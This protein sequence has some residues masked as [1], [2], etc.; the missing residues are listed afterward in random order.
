[1]A[2][3][4]VLSFTRTAIGQK[5]LVAVTGIILYGFAFFHAL[6]N[7]QVFLGREA[8]NQYAEMLQSMPKLVWATRLVLLVALITHVVLV[9]RLARRA[10][11]AKPAH[12]RFEERMDPSEGI[13]RR[14]ARQTMLL[15]G[16]IILAYIVFHLM[17]LTVGAVPGLFFVRGMAYENLIYGMRTPWVAG[18]YLFANLLLGLHLYH[19]CRALFQTLGLRHPQWD[20]RSFAMALSITAVIVGTNVIIPIAGLTRLVGGELPEDPQEVLRTGEEKHTVSE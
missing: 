9:V 16:L 13:L 12:Y 18:F 6:G 3:S 8:F 11:E 17:H 15:S 1:M 14:Y 2:S 20:R 7:L 4:Q 19:G 5:A 10:R